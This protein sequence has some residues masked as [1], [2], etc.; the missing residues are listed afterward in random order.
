MRLE[1]QNGSTPAEAFGQ[2][3]GA[4][5][6]GD[7]AAVHPV[8]IPD[9]DHSSSKPFR[10]RLGI[11][12]IHEILG[13]QLPGEGHFL[14]FDGLG[15]TLASCPRF[16][17]LRV[18]NSSGSQSPF[19]YHV[20]HVLKHLAVTSENGHGF[21]E[22]VPNSAAKF[23]AEFSGSYSGRLNLSPMAR[24][25]AM[26][27]EVA[28]SKTQSDA[29]APNCCIAARRRRT[30]RLPDCLISAVVPLEPTGAHIPADTMRRN[31]CSAST[32]VENE[33]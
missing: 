25:C 33:E 22:L 17:L 28:C 23:G 12:H 30:R 10:R 15:Q 31:P 7:V 32:S 9:R 20:S 26:S 11:G 2:R 18:P 8:E 13:Q 14:R 6:H 1:G 29:T 27:N 5:D 21:N 24:L 19:Y 4:S 16:R 3:F